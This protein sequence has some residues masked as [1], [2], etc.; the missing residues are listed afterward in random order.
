[1]Q[2]LLLLAFFAEDVLVHILDAF[3]LI[4]L[5]LTPSADICRNLT[6]KLFVV[7]DNLDLRRLR[8]VDRDVLRKQ[9]DHRVAEPKVQLQITSEQLRAKTNTDDLE[10]AREAVADSFSEIFSKRRSESHA[11]EKRYDF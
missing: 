4:R 8:H 10:L 9:K 3:A 5:W 2:S 1:M 7:S 6:D 11:E